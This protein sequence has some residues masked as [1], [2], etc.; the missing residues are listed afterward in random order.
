MWCHFVYALLCALFNV[1]V[2]VQINEGICGV[3]VCMHVSCDLYV[4]ISDENNDSLDQYH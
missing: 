3:Y 4:Y 2:G 1:H